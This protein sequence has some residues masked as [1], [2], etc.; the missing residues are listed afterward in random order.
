L[1]RCT[2]GEQVSCAVQNTSLH[3]VSNSAQ[4]PPRESLGARFARFWSKR[5]PRNASAGASVEKIF[6]LGK[7]DTAPPF[8]VSIADVEHDFHR[9]R[10]I[11]IEYA[12]CVKTSIP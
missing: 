5:P 9:A 10:E 11:R 4:A 6:D 2:P 3:S 7:T 8:A 12:T 1:T